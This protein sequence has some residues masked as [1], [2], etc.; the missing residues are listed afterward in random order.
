MS[1]VGRGRRIELRGTVQGVGMRP[2]VWR[3]ALELGLT[4]RVWNHPAGV[5]V[6]AFGPVPALD[7]LAA[8]LGSGGPPSAR[9]VSLS[10]WEIPFEAAAG[11]VIEES[12]GTD[13]R[14]V[15][16]PADLSTCP[17][18]LRELRDPAD[19]RFRYPFLNCTGCGP[20]FTIVRD[21]PYDRSATT[22]AGFAMCPDCAREYR[23]PSDRRFHAEP[24]AC[25]ACGPRVS[26]VAPDGAPVP[27][28]DPIALAGAA[29]AAGRI[30]AVKGLGGY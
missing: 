19:R 8:R 26:L 7:A 16:I 18:C 13:E 4:G 23:D 9:V 15:S 1:E 25:P 11:F 29:L 22:M 30:L 17:A 21:I 5:T 12:A 20:R 27:S 28:A 6:E 3:L 2:F 10:A 14:R 24:T